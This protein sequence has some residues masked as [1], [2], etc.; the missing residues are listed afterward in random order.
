MTLQSTSLYVLKALTSEAKLALQAD[1]R[2]F[3]ELPF[4]V[5]RDT[6]SLV[7][8]ESREITERRASGMA[9]NNELYLRETGLEV[10]VS[11]EHFLIDTVD[12]E[13]RLV[14]RNSALGTWVEGRL[15]G[16]DRRGGETRLLSGDIIIPGSY[17]SGFIF[18]FV[19]D[20]N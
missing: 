10:Y 8:P 4:R 1:A 12:G 16:G 9:P 20:D 19:V 15:I 6:R 11:R 2:S 17:K 14:D 13:Y 3:G 5:G 18:K 7:G